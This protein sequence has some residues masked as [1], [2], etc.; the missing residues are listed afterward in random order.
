MCGIVESAYTRYWKESRERAM[1]ARH[2]RPSVASGVSDRRIDGRSSIYA[3]SWTCLRQY[4]RLQQDAGRWT[5]SGVSGGSRLSLTA[6]VC[7]A[8]GIDRTTGLRARRLLS[9]G[10]RL[11]RTSW[12]T[13]VSASQAHS[14]FLRDKYWT[15]LFVYTCIPDER[16]D[17]RIGPK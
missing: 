8:A 10:V 6:P 7:G 17:G 14:F 4:T 16:T 12:L 9:K 5:P 3:R 1:V 11:E 2:V 15:R 13:N